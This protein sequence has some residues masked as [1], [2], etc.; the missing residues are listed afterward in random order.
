MKI[1]LQNFDKDENAWRGLTGKGRA[2]WLSFDW[3]E[4]GHTPEQFAIGSIMKVSNSC[5]VIQNEG[6]MPYYAPNAGQAKLLHGPS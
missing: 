3:S 6:D 5:D 2:V 1:T 4:F